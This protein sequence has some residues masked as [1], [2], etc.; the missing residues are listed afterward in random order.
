[1]RFSAKQSKVFADC[2]FDLGVAWQRSVRAHAKPLGCLDLGNAVILDALLD[3]D[4]GRLLRE[5]LSR[6]VATVRLPFSH[7]LQ[8]SC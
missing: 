1:M 8:E 4:A 6:A 5:N 7:G 2:F 3:D